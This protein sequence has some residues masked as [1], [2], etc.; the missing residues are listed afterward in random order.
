[1]FRIFRVCNIH[2][3]PTDAYW[4]TRTGFECTC[5]R[6]HVCVYTCTHTHTHTYIYIYI[7]EEGLTEVE[8]CYRYII[9]I[10]IM[11]IIIIIISGSAAQRGLWSPILRGFL[12]KHDAPQSLELLWT[13]DQLVAQTST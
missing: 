13:S 7:S 1:M 12:I 8:I 10:M 11:I 4:Y 6:T 5:V 2:H 3:T 9:I